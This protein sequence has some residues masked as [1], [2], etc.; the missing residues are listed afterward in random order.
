MTLPPVPPRPLL[1]PQLEELADVASSVGLRTWADTGTAL[2]LARQGAAIHAPGKDDIDLSVWVDDLHTLS[3]AAEALQE[4]GYVQERWYWRG[5]L[6]KRKFFRP[7]DPDSYH[8]DF[9]IYRRFG[10]RCWTPLVYHRRVRTKPLWRAAR[11]LRLRAE[12]SSPDRHLGSTRLGL[13]IGIHTFVVPSHHFERLVAWEDTALLMPSG[14]D[15][16][17]TLHYGDWRTPVSPWN[18]VTQDGAVHLG[19]PTAVI[20]APALGNPRATDA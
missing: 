19:T 3:A 20:G 2:G 12:R 17:L 9:K 11:A 10:Q 8:V 7:H 18:S 15:V 4:R 14:L 5:L 13:W 1:S 6:F 16:L